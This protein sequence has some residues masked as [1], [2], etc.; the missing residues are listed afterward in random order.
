MLGARCA[1]GENHSRCCG[2]IA[3]AAVMLT[4]FAEGAVADTPVPSYTQAVIHSPSPETTGFQGFGIALGR[5]GDVDRDGAG[6]VIASD[7]AQ[8]VSG[9]SGAGRVGLQWPGLA[10]SLT[11]T[12]PGSARR[13]GAR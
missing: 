1:G 5:A 12:S 6:D 13:S 11:L 4:C 8:T 9:L 2:A 7:T 3:A 10:S